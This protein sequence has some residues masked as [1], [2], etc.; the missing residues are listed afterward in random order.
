MLLVRKKQGLAYHKRWAKL[1]SPIGT[2]ERELIIQQKQP[3]C[4][5]PDTSH[6]DYETGEDGCSVCLGFQFGIMPLSANE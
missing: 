6:K 4:R 3:I 5:S 2:R 1:T